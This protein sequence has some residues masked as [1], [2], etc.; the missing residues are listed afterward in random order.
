MSD[1]TEQP[2]TEAPEISA[3]ALEAYVPEGSAEDG[4]N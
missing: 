3:E 4:T 2:N 1:T